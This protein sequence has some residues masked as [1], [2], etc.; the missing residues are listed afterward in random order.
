MPVPTIPVVCQ[1]IWATP[2]LCLVNCPRPNAVPALLVTFVRKSL[3]LHAMRA[4]S[5]EWPHEVGTLSLPT[6]T[7]FA[8][9]S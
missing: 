4:I 9:E 6:R 1:L 7:A 2:M 8:I 3:S 5:S